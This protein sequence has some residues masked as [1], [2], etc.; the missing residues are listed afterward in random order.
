MTEITQILG[1]LVAILS[2]ISLLGGIF[3]Y[4]RASTRKAYAAERDF[5]HLKRNF[6]QLTI[7]TEQLWRRV[8]ETHEKEMLE[9]IRIS[10]K[11]QSLLDRK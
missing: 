10:E 8:D 11:M 9:L 7:N 2:A 6:D 5:N 1:I 4:Q 3:A